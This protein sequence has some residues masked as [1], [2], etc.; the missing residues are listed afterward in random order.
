MDP[1][2]D[3]FV[4]SDWIGVGKTYTSD[5]P[6]GVIFAKNAVLEIPPGAADLTPAP[7]LPVIEFASLALPTQSAELVY[8]ESRMWFTSTT[9][10]LNSATYPE[11]LHCYKPSSSA[12]SRPSHFCVC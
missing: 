1:D 5:V 10:A 12:T 11:Q 4:P 8:G 3:S 7:T 2:D 6:L 9:M